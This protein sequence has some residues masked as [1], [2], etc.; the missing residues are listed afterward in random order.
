MA[1]SLSSQIEPGSDRNCLS[2]C[3]LELGVSEIF[4]LN[5][6]EQQKIKVLKSHLKPQIFDNSKDQVP[7]IHLL[8]DVIFKTFDDLSEKRVFRKALEGMNS[9][10]PEI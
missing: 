4:N 3:H 7:F 6:V 5:V 9:N 10:Y 2:S 8:D 1:T